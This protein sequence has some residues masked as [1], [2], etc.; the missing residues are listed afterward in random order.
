[1]PKDKRREQS[2]HTE[3][4][5]EDII[6]CYRGPG[7]GCIPLLP[8]MSYK[9]PTDDTNKRNDCEI[10]EFLKR[11]STEPIHRHRSLFFA[12]IKKIFKRAG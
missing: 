9:E 2:S 10:P 5:R 11:Q 1:M 4:T 7:K 3:I 12:F 8:G 6:W